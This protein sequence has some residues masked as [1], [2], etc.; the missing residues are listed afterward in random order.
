MRIIRSILKTL[1]V[2]FRFSWPWIKWALLRAL[3]FTTLALVTL[4]AGVPQTVREFAITN[5]NNA[6]AA[7]IPLRF[8][9]FVYWASVVIAGV[10]ILIG[11]V[12]LAYITVFVIRFLIAIF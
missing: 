11:W 9:R 1:Y 5:T 4:W 10:E 8:T 2:T 6:V 3:Y 7:R 12:I